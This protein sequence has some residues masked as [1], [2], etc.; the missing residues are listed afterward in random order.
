MSVIFCYKKVDFGNSLGILAIVMQTVS[1]KNT[2]QELLDAYEALVREAKEKDSTSPKLPTTTIKTS[3]GNFQKAVET[4]IVVKSAIDDAVSSL[5]KQ[6]LAQ[7]SDEEQAQLELSRFREDMKRTREELDY[8][9]KRLRQEKTDELETELATRQRQHETRLIE[10]NE[11]FR[12]RQ[13]MLEVQED[14]LEQ[15][16]RKATLFPKELE[17]TVQD[18]TNTTRVEEQN[19]AKVVRDLMEKQVEGERALAKLKIENLE[20]T[21]KEQAEEIR[22]LRSQ[23]ERATSQVKDIAVSVIDSNRPVSPATAKE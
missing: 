18:M 15:L 21:T 20:K 14:E 5:E 22:Q 11:T 4:L 6:K 2:K 12:H 3:A 8:E 13:E 19:K 1:V 16:R 10:E 17:K 23:L 9:L 7:I